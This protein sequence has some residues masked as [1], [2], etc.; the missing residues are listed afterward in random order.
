MTLTIIV[1]HRITPQSKKY[2][3]LLGPPAPASR[4]EELPTEPPFCRLFDGRAVFVSHL[5]LFPSG[6]VYCQ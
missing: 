4:T 5:F 3:P 1:L 6:F 2:K